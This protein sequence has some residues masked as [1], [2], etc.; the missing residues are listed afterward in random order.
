MLAAAVNNA[1]GEPNPAGL[2]A[3]LR[4]EFDQGAPLVVMTDSSWRT[5]RKKSAAVVEGRRL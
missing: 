1:G 4:I 2:I 3:L 5:S